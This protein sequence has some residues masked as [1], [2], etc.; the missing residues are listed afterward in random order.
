MITENY[1]WS[2]LAGGHNYHQIIQRIENLNRKQAPGL[3]KHHIEPERKRVVWLKPLEHLAIHI[4]HAFVE[5]TG[6]F[7]AKVGAFVR[8]FPGSYR[9]LLTLDPG[10]QEQL[11]S[12]G[13]KRPGNG[14]NLQRH[15]NTISA[16]T[17]PRTERQKASA[18]ENGRK[19]AEKVRQ[20]LLG[21][22]ITWGGKISNNIQ[23]RGTCCCLICGREMLAWPSNIIQHQRSK[24]CSDST[25]KAK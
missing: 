12:F 4:A 13:Q 16:R 7:Y 9:R 23:S 5:N 1:I 15:P 14:V 2:L 8:P 21:R 10:L 11:V 3:E 22:D 20:K 17:A 25:K 6:A 18:A 19:S 24:K